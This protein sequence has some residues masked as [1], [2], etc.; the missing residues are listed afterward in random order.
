[1][2]RAKEVENAGATIIHCQFL[3]NSAQQGG[4]LYAVHNA[5]DSRINSSIFLFNEAANEGGA[6]YCKEDDSVYIHFDE[7]YSASNSAG[8]RGGFAYSSNCLIVVSGH[9]ISENKAPNGGAIYAE[10]DSEIVISHS[11]VANNTAVNSGAALYHAFLAT[12]AF[13]AT[14][15]LPERVGPFLFKTTTVKWSPTIPDVF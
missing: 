1:M 2:Q 8:V 9:N 13:L 12:K 4:V 11:T 3:N 5:Y 10:R 14:M 7:G 6:I 15:R